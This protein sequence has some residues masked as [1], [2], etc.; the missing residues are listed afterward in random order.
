[1]SLG[2]RCLRL[3]TEPV[4]AHRDRTVR[5]LGAV[6]GI[7]RAPVDGHRAVLARDFK[8]IRASRRATLRGHRGKTVPGMSN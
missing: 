3:G 7:R 5:A 2:R 4:I 8:V 1:M 6:F